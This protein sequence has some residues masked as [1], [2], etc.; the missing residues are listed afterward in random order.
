MSHDADRSWMLLPHTDE[1]WQAGFQQFIEKEFQG[2]YPGQTAACTCC[3]CHCL[4]YI[5][6]I[7]VEQHLLTKGFDKDFIKQKRRVAEP[8]DDDC[9]F[10]EAEARDDSG[11]TKDLLTSLISGAIDGKITGSGD[12]EEPNESA[13]KFFNLMQ[14][15][16]KELYPGCKEAT[17]VSFIV[18][19]FQCMFGI[20]NQGMEQILH[21]FSLL[22]PEGHC[23]PDSLDKVRK[24]VRDL[25]LDYEKIHACVNDCVLF[26]G[27]YK[28]MDE[29]PTCGESRWKTRDPD[30]A[31]KPLPRKILRYFP[32][33]PR[34]RRLYMNEI[35]S[36]HMRWH[37]EKLV[38]DG[39]MRHPA[40]SLAW[41]HVDEQYKEFALDPCNVR[42]ALASDGFNP[43]GM[44]NVTY[45]T[46]P[47]ILIPY[48]LPPWLCL[49]QSYWMMSMLIP[50]PKSPGMTIDVYL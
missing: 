34:L 49:K 45:T 2:N 4:V 11:S 33:V 17:K 29:C 15:A 43:F 13:K 31:K 27:A 41:K 22:L 46:W 32:L 47:V 40:D 39:K 12:K 24:V 6:K 36:L 28:D 1:A 37:K 30:G 25:G 23:V 8:M 20:S 5:T 18:R 16:K 42:L 21:L 35:T 38:Q 50:G 3:R 26:H 7:E 48:N 10:S 19:L 44:L 9:D 14:E